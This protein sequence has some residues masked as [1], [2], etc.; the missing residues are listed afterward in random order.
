MKYLLQ[1][2]RKYTYA[3]YDK[4]KKKWLPYPYEIMDSGP[5]YTNEQVI[6]FITQ[7]TASINKHITKLNE[8]VA[9]LIKKQKE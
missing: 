1:G 2:G 9:T 5:K 3:E 8:I 7:H 4:A 6:Q